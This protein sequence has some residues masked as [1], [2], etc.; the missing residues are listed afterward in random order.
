MNHRNRDVVCEVGE[1]D[2]G[3]GRVRQ[4]ARAD[5]LTPA[6]P[7]E[8][9]EAPPQQKYL[10]NRDSAKFA[11]LDRMSAAQQKVIHDS[12]MAGRY[13]NRGTKRTERVIVPG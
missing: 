1:E 12:I 6:L 5:Y 9:L 2:G 13:K 11:G 7:Q 3:E 4:Y 8:R 10:E